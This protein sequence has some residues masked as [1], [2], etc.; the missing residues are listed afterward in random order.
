FKQSNATVLSSGAQ[1]DQARRQLEFADQNLDRS[2]LPA[3][4]AGTIARV[5]IKSFAQVAAGQ[6]VAT[7]YRDDSFEMNFLD[8]ATTFQSLK[9]GQKV[10]VKVADKPDLPL[11]G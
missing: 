9:V 4:F 8:P 7:L 10:E 3:P 11:K 2:K 5:E 6:P 1:L